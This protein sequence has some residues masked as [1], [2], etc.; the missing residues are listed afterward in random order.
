[1]YEE[2]LLDPP[3]QYLTHLFAP[4]SLVYNKLY[5]P[6]LCYLFIKY[7]THQILPIIAM[8]LVGST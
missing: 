3:M 7:T 6:E 5:N 1:M 8:D 4:Y 2:P